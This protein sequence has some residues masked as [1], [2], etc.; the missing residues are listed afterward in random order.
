[1]ETFSQYVRTA[2]LRD[3]RINPRTRDLNCTI[4]FERTDE[5]VQGAEGQVA[6]S[7]IRTAGNW[8]IMFNEPQFHF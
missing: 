7:C 1:M 3:Y 8:A 6:E 5:E 4:G 2:Q